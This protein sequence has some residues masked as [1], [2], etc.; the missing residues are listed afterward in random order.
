M[1]SKLTI[2]DECSKAADVELLVKQS[3][4]RVEGKPSESTRSTESSKQRNVPPPPPKSSSTSSSSSS[5]SKRPPQASA[6]ELAMRKRIQRLAGDIIDAGDAD[7]APW[8]DMLLR[9]L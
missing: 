7:S 2:V 5:G 6:D 1:S 9:L 8:R 4:G 3:S